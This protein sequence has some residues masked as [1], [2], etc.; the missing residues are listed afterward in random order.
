MN[1]ITHPLHHRFPARF[2]LALLLPLAT[3]LAPGAERGELANGGF[4]ATEAL[5]GWDLTVY[6]ARPE[7]HADREVRHE[8]TQSLRVSATELSDTA[9]AQEL[10]L[11]PNCCYRFSGWVKTAGLSASSAPVFGTLQVQHPGGHGTIAGGK[12]H[13]GDTDW[14]EVPVCFVTPADGCVRLCLF[15]AGFGKATGTVWFDDLKLEELDP[16]RCPIRVARNILGTETIHPFQYGQFIEYL[17]DLVPAMWAEKLYDGSF[18][19]L[20]PYKFEFRKET[21]FKEKPW[22]PSGAVNRAEYAL[23]RETK[24]SGDVS[25]RITVREGAPCTVG[26]AQDGLF[27]EAKAA[28][29]FKCWLRA[30]GLR[31]PVRVRLHRENEVLASCEF[32]P[33]SSWQRFSARLTPVRGEANAT[34]TLDFKGPGHLWLDNVSLM[35]VD[36]VGGWRQDVVVAVRALKPGLIRFGGSTVDEPGFGDFEWKDT[37]GDPDRR[38]PFR[39]WGGLQP[40]GP[41]LE[42]IVQFCRVVGAEPLICVR[43]NGRLPKDAAEE[44]EYFNG[45]S[46]TPMGAWRARNGHPEPYRVRFW[47]IGNELSGPDYERRLA[48]FCQ[49]MKAADPAIQLMSSFPS[50][51]VLKEA[52]AWLDFVCPHHYSLDLAWMENDLAAVSRMVRENAPGRA[53]KIG[54]TEWNTTAGDRGPGRAMLWT[55][56]NALACSRYHNLLHRHCDQ[57]KIANRSN[58]I[59]S[60]CSGILQTDNHRLFRTPTYF[61]Q[62][63]YATLAGDRPLEILSELPAN[64]AP[65]LSATLSADGRIVTLFAVNDTLQDITRPM[66][67]SAFGATPKTIS[68]WTLADRERSGEPDA[69]NSFGDPGRIQPVQSKLKRVTNPFACRFPALSLSVLRWEVG[70]P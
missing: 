11:K 13:G 15:F 6:G 25:K 68:V 50:T 24:V 30:E 1:I 57:V 7:I 55:L 49:A 10:T 31:G 16:A 9:L 48:A 45:G 2:L 52:A 36:T 60:F 62:Q 19:G 26:L 35:P 54:V 38:R 59:N 53:I 69:A 46:D 37:I 14:T 18:E 33:G 61:A 27:L 22:Y 32:R 47:Q 39:A 64:L 21:D 70:Q 65:D 66:D 56:S 4:E 67:L 12:N 41:G 29:D 23:D 63:L 34:L 20:S 8:G 3:I 17:C 58:L 28:C 5:Q 43:F 51:G 42:E 40:T 44:V